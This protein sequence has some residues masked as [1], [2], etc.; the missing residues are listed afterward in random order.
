MSGC[1]KDIDCD[2]YRYIPVAV[3]IK[4]DEAKYHLSKMNKLAKLWLKE[5]DIDVQDILEEQFRE[6]RKKYEGAMYYVS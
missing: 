3:R 2:N 4:M 6:H 1:P 5:T